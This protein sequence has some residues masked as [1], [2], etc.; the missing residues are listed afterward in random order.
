MPWDA[1]RRG[2]KWVVLSKSG[3]VLGTHP[4]KKAARQQ[5]KALYYS[6]GKKSKS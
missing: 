1:I 6:E 4:T 3:R 2:D 5:Q